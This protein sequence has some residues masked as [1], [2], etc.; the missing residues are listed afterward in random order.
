ME[1][2]DVFYAFH[3]DLLEFV[4]LEE[5]LECCALVFDQSTPHNCPDSEENEEPNLYL[6]FI[7]EGINH[8][9]MRPLR[10]IRTAPAA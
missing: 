6:Q 4:I 10:F 3:E 2:I 8:L 9:R 1:E 7:V 5:C